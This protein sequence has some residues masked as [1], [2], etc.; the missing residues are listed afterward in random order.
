MV[1]VQA[2]RQPLLYIVDDDAEMRRLL[3]QYFGRH[4]FDVVT[5]QSGDELL[6]RL[7]RRR[8]DIVVL[9]LMMPGISGLDAL[10]KLREEGDDIPLILLT[11]LSAENERI[12]G[13]D[14]GAD[15]YLGKPFNPRELLSRV[16]AVLRRRTP[17]KLRLPEQEGPMVVG[18]FVLDPLKRVVTLDGVAVA[19]TDSD[20]TLLRAM[21][22]HPL[23]PLTRT[24]LVEMCGRPP[25]DAAERAI[26]VQILRLRRLLEADPD[27]PTLLQ[28]V[29]GVGY[30][31]VPQ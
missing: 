27:N 26:N 30:V 11:A 21:A 4:G 7:S 18:R 31:F 9:D 1:Q 10:R 3:E 28:T 20:F 6:H 24:R 13:L 8:P 5:L 22:T 2:A 23:K 12:R 19:L 14:L 15:D 16:H 17:M 29:R 25:G